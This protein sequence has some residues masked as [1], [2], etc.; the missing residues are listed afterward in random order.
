MNYFKILLI[1]GL[2]L[3]QESLIG[4]NASDLAKKFVIATKA[5][6]PTADA[7]VKDLA[8]LEIE[9]I[10]KELDTDQ[11]KIAFWVNV[12]NA[13]THYI[14][15]S[16]PKLF[17][18]RSDFFKADQ[19]N[20]GGKML[21]LDF[22]EHGLLRRSKNK[23]SLGYLGKFNVSKFEKSNRVNKVD[24]RIHYA[25]NCG[26]KSCPP[27]V[28]YDAEKL[29][30][31]FDQS[32]QKYLDKHTKWIDGRKKLE[33]PVLFRWFLNDFG[34]KKGIEKIL[35]KYNIIKESEKPNLTYG[36]YDWTLDL[37]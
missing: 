7:C 17:E 24:W 10:S 34:G 14:L 20:I 21:S 1:A 23:Y 19:I 12:Y 2:F 18:N 25:L 31:Q 32:T 8:T 5:N 11:K 15:K 13:F 29:N 22:I 28:P 26:A 4:Q 27:V 33:I 6:D 16:N 30:I 9:K 3:F 36:D 37:N 35:K